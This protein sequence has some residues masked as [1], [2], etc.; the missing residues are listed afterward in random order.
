MY[1]S[2]P[3]AAWLEAQGWQHLEIEPVTRQAALQAFVESVNSGRLTQFDGIHTPI[4]RA[5]RKLHGTD[6]VEM[7]RNWIGSSQ[8]WTC[9]CCGRAKLDVSR[10]GEKGQILAKLVVHHDHMDAALAAAFNAAFEAFGT[11]T[12]QV[13]GKALV[14]RIK[15]AFAAYTEVLVCEDCNNADGDAKRLLRLPTHFSFALS[16]I[17]SFIDVRA[18]RAHVLRRNDVEQ[19]WARAQSAFELRMKIIKAVAKASVTDAHWFEPHAG[20]GAPVPVFPTRVG[21][22][23]DFQ[24]RRWLWYDDVLKALGPEPTASSRN[25][26]RWRTE[27]VAKGR[28]VPSNFVAM[29]RSDPSRAAQWNKVADDWHCPICRRSKTETA[30][31]GDEGKINFIVRGSPRRSAWPGP[32]CNHCF[33]TLSALKREV[34]EIVG[35]GAEPDYSFVSVE[36]FQAIIVARAHSSHAVRLDAARELVNRILH[37]QTGQ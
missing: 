34:D 16:Q 15:S 2:H 30:Y 29:L 10:L 26:S 23:V 9:P 21:V 24:V 28:A 32:I 1:V 37:E 3:F 8:D 25:L 12:E 14:D 36:D 27:P 13:G 5:L 6:S 19:A 31:V 18:N 22:A 33:A 20:P 11:T 35:A 7:N 17:G 4:G